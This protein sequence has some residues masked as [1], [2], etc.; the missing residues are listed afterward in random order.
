MA[1]PSAGQA[2]RPPLPSIGKLLGGKSSPDFDH[3]HQHS[4]LSSLFG[5]GET[6]GLMS[7]L[8]LAHDRMALEANVATL[9]HYRCGL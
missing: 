4:H 5:S 1:K 7:K 9:Q 8:I 2:P 6:M 3:Y